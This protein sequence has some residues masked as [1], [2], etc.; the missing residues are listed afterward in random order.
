MRLF[1]L[2]AALVLAGCSSG[3]ATLPISTYADGNAARPAEVA[4]AAEAL[5]DCAGLQVAP[6]VVQFACED[7][8][9]VFAA[10]Y[11][12]EPTP[13]AI[14]DAC[15]AVTAELFDGA[16]LTGPAV[17]L[18]EP[19]ATQTVHTSESEHGGSLVTCSV[20]REGGMTVVTATPAMA[21]VDPAAHV[22]PLAWDG[23]PAGIVTGVRPDSVAFVGR[24]LPLRGNCRLM[25]PQNLSCAPYGQMSWE[26]FSSVDLARTFEAEKVAQ[27]TRLGG[28]VRSDEQVECTF[29]GQATTCR[30]VVF[31]AP[32]SRVLTLGA[33][34]VL[35]AVYATGEVR[36]VPSQ[37]VCSYFDDQS[38][39]GVLAPLCREA[40]AL[41]NADVRPDES[42]ELTGGDETP[43]ASGE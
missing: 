39:E 24:M 8:E 29:E 4:P 13:E 26:R 40:F 12:V 43:E 22:E 31:R 38:P 6:Y 9:V 18:P 5:A 2:A 27:L 20:A 23:V 19:A 32:I 10:R 30:R 25:G 34:N 11:D 16:V 33:S 41:S 28:E 35:I 37:V 17:R 3:V 42:G 36:G 21:P 7:A 1:A 14:S 15:L